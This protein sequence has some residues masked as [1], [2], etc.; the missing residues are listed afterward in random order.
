MRNADRRRGASCEPGYGA[1][2]GRWARVF[3][4]DTEWSQLKASS[5]S[6]RFYRR[7]GG[8]RAAGKDA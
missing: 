7:S 4:A 2:R 5:V 8:A 3:V 1:K 6:R